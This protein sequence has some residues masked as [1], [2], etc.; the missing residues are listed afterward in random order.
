MQT[1]NPAAF[2]TCT[3]TRESIAAYIQ[4]EQERGASKASIRNFKRVTSSLYE[5]LPNDKTITKD[6]L[7][8]WRKSLKDYG[9]TQRTELNYVKGINRYL[10]YIGCSDIRFNRGRAKDI[11]G[12]Q[13]GYLTAIE[14]TGE[15]YRKDYV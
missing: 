10:D 9:Y 5:W 2:A 11:A 1:E 4:N 3:M 15:K 14:P 13:F 8:A 6:L 7:L 12:K